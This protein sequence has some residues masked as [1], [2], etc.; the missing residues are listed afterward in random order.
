MEKI[1]TAVPVALRGAETKD[2]VHQVIHF[3]AGKSGQV[4][5]ICDQRSPEVRP[6]RKH[7]GMAFEPPH[8]G[9][10]R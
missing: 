5:S 4:C 1:G 9:H 3:L 2:F 8:V 6:R 7:S 10:A